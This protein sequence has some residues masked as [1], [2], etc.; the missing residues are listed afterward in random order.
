[1]RNELPVRKNIRLNDY[2]YSAAGYYYVT[3]CVKD[4]HK[5]LGEF[6]GD[7]AHIVPQTMIKS[8]FGD[9]VDKYIKNIETAYNDVLVDKYVIMPI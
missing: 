7:D 8:K 9:I 3:I 2:D 5:L 6:V 1:M 4:K